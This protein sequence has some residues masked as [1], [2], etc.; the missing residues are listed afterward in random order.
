MGFRARCTGLRAI[1]ASTRVTIRVAIQVYLRGL[2]HSNRVLGIHNT[3]GNRKEQ[4][5]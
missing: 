5:R 2:N 4:C 3:V 1:R